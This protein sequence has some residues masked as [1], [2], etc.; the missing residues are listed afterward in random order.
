MTARTRSFSLLAVLVVVT[1]ALAG[2]PAPNAT[3]RAD[4]ERLEL[5]RD[6]ARALN[7]EETLAVAGWQNSRRLPPARGHLLGRLAEVATADAVTVARQETAEAIGAL[8]ANGWTV[9]LV[10][11]VP[12]WTDDEPV[13]ED[14]VVPQPAFDAW[15][16]VAYGYKVVDGVSYFVEVHGS[17]MQPP[18]RAAVSL[19]L[20]APYSRETVTD[21]FPDRPP[22]TEV[23][24][25]CV[26]RATPLDGLAVL[27]TPTVMDEKGPV[28]GEPMAEG[29]R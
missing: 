12:P 26:E 24:A 17:G 27:G 8:R 4:R 1:A 20:I 21:L 13:D 11:C 23:G 6:E 2:C 19:R 15:T 14:S 25:S 9:Y 10:A 29:H 5:L 28:D 7:A 16:F 3:T 22:A 18:G